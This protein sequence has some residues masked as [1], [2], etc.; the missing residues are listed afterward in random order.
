[1]KRIIVCRR[2]EGRLRR[3]RRQRRRR[4]RRRRR[5]ATMATTAG[6]SCPA[7]TFCGLSRD[8]PKPRGAIKLMV[9]RAGNSLRSV[10]R[11][12]T[13]WPLRLV[14]CRGR[15]PRSTS[16][17]KWFLGSDMDQREPP[18]PFSLFRSSLSTDRADRDRTERLYPTTL[19]STTRI[20]LSKLD[21]PGLL[22][23]CPLTRILRNFRKSV[24]V[25]SVNSHRGS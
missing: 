18:L 15:I 22:P 3:R 19:P 7:G 14:I 16:T 4:R 1:M 10:C 6:P 2:G 11:K 8:E 23:L 13:T 20:N 21:A 9:T 24:F 25:V 17:D 5:S 12:S